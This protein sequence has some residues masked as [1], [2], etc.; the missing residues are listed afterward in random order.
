MYD[1]LEYTDKVRANK[2]LLER[3][4]VALG[5]VQDSRRRV[6]IRPLVEDEVIVLAKRLDIELNTWANVE[7]NKPIFDRTVTPKED[8]VKEINARLMGICLEYVRDQY[9]LF[10]IEESKKKYL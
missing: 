2:F 1:R 5:Q 10:P 7:R 3:W 9:D 8:K 4:T 6:G